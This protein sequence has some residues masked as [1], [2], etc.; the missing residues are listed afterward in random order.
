MHSTFRYCSEF[1][2][3]VF[4]EN[5]IQNIITGNASNRNNHKEV[6]LHIFCLATG[7]FQ[8][9]PDQAVVYQS[10]SLQ[11]QSRTAHNCSGNTH[12]SITDWS[13]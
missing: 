2:Q 1:S 3:P 8:V 4:V 11:L 7:G 5:S 12:F 6:F 10:F 9:A 13:L